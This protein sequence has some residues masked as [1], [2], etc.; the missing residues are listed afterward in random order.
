MPGKIIFLCVLSRVFAAY[1]PPRAVI[2]PKGSAEDEG[3]M[4]EP[5]K[6]MRSTSEGLKTAW[7]R[8]P[9]FDP[10][11]EKIT[12]SPLE[13]IDLAANIEDPFSSFKGLEI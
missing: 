6:P 12:T 8:F 3:L 11:T 4:E 9:R 7:F 10:E 5:R 2:C 1:F 13:T